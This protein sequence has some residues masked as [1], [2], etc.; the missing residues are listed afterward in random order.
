[1]LFAVTIQA[2]RTGRLT[3][4]F[5]PSSRSDQVSADSTAHS[6]SESSRLLTLSM[7]TRDVPV[8]KKLV[9]FF[10]HSSA[11]LGAVLIAAS[12]PATTTATIL[13]SKLLP[14]PGAVASNRARGVGGSANHGPNHWREQRGYCVCPRG[15][16]IKWEVA[17]QIINSR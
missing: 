14:V 5:C 11:V 12:L 4:T 6:S 3:S 7:I 2:H 17:D 13:A 8:R 16:P 15:V 10:R 1:M 9:I